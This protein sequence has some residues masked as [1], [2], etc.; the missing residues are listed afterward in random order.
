[1]RSSLDVARRY[2]YISHVRQQPMPTIDP[3]HIDTPHALLYAIHIHIHKDSYD[4]Q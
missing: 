1:M 3:A 2:G 4:S